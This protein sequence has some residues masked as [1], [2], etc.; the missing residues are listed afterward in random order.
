MT[1][2]VVFGILVV[3]VCV[4]LGGYQDQLT[5]DI[6]YHLQSN[7]KKKKIQYFHNL[8]GCNNI[9]PDFYGQGNYQ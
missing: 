1:L 3:Q 5:F 8:P 4:P 9:E 7:N 6:S 2:V